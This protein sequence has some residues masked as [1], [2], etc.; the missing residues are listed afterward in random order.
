[1]FLHFPRGKQGLHCQILY[2]QSSTTKT[3]GKI[4]EDSEVTHTRNEDVIPFNLLTN[5]FYTYIHHGVIVKEM[6]IYGCDDDSDDFRCLGLR[7]IPT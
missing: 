5:V 4:K 2:V 6:N 7:L 1:M 3:E